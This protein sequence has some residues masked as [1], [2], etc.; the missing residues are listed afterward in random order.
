MKKILCFIAF[1]IFT[2]SMALGLSSCKIGPGKTPEKGNEPEEEKEN[3]IFN[4]TSELYIIMG[5]NA[6]SELAFRLQNAVDSA[7]VCKEASKFGNSS[8][9]QQKHE[10]V[11]GNTDRPISSVAK[12]HLGRI[13]KLTDNEVSFLIYSD[14][15]SVA[16]VFDE[17]DKDVTETMAIEYFIEHYTNAKEM[18]AAKGDLHKDSFDLIEDYYRVLDNEYRNEQWEAL[19]EAL[20]EGYADEFVTAMQQLYSLYSPD[21]VTWYANL[22]E[23]NICI[24]YGLYGEDRCD[25][26]GSPYCGTAGIYYS[27][28]G[29]DTIGYLPD[30]E[31]TSQAI[32]FMESSGMSYMYDNKPKNWLPEEMKMKMG[33]YA[34]AMQDEDGFFYHPQWGRDFIINNQKDSRRARDLGHATNLLGIAALKPFYTTPTGVQGSTDLEV[35]GKLTAPFGGSTVSAVS[36]VV[37]TAGNYAEHLENEKTFREYLESYDIRHNSYSV[38]NRIGSQMSQIQA[39]DKAIGT[40]SDPTPLMDELMD[41]LIKNQNPETGCWNW[42]YKESGAPHTGSE[43][44]ESVNGLLK[45]VNDFT[46]AGVKMPYAREAAV[47]AMAAITDPKPIDA[48]TSL[49]NTWYAF[50]WIIENLRTCGGADGNREADELVAL[51]RESAVEGIRVSREKISVFMNDDGSFS[52]GINN[53]VPVSAQTSQGC[54]V[55]LPNSEEGDV[56]AT[57]IAINGIKNHIFECLEISHLRPILFGEAERRIYLDIIENASSVRKNEVELTGEPITFDDEDTG[58]PSEELVLELGAGSANVVEDPRGEGNV[59]KIISHSGSGDYITVPNQSNSAL[60]M[61]YVFE[62]EFM[63]ESSSLQGD[64]YFAQFYMGQKNYTCYFFTLTLKDGKVIAKEHSSSSWATA[65]EETL[66]EVGTLGEWFK[67]KVEYYYSESMDDVRIKFWYD[68]N[69]EDGEDMKLLAVTDNFYDATGNKYL[70]GQATPCKYFNYTRFYMMSGTEAVLYMDNCMT[71]KTQNA[72][73]PMTDINNQPPINID[74]P[75]SPE[76]IYDFEDGN[77][78]ADFTLTGSGASVKNNSLS[79]TSSATLNIPVNIR[80]MGARCVSTSFLITPTAANNGSTVMR[81][82]GLD[83][84]TAMFGINVA[85]REDGDGKYLTLVEYDSK[86]TGNELTNVRIPFGKSTNVRLDY[87]HKEDMIIIYVDG[88]F[89]AATNVFYPDGIKGTMDNLNIVSL[90]SS[91]DITLDNIRVEKN[92]DLFLDA[93]APTTP[94]KPYTFDNDEGIDKKGNITVSGGLLAVNSKAGAGS[95]SV[96][97]HERANLQ[98]ILKFSADINIKEAASDGEVTKLLFTDSEGN[99]IFALA[100]VKRGGNIDLCQVSA[101]GTVAEPLYSYAFANS[102]NITLEI[103]QDKKMVHLI[104]G[105]TVKAK[106]SVFYTPENLSLECV[107]ATVASA[108]VKG[109]FTLDNLI[110]ESYYGAYIKT[111]IASKVTPDETLSEGLNF[112]LSNS[113]KLPS[114]NIKV[115]QNSPASAVR[116]E[117][118]V[119]TLMTD[120]NPD[121][122]WSNVFAMDTGAGANDSILIEASEPMAGHSCVSFETDIM[123]STDMQ[124]TIFQI[125]LSD[126]SRNNKIIMIQVS[127]T[128]DNMIQLDE[129]SRNSMQDVIANPL[130]NSVKVGEWFNLRVEFYQGSK[131]TV[132]LKYF[133]NGS[134]VAISNNFYGAHEPG[135][136]PN[137]LFDCVQIMSLSAASG[138]VYLDN[139]SLEASNATCKEPVTVENSPN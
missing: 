109:V 86:A 7:R 69:L 114:D 88:E 71:Y 116:V 93:V 127:V 91:Y 94:S 60:A 134:L 63:L 110:F 117:Q 42:R 81:L 138:T 118:M 66:G 103:Y 84:D 1:L 48:V 51:I 44:Y 62:S 32:G 125:F 106:T 83:G 29:R 4:S 22:Y 65:V 97:V 132:R 56:N 102:F 74:P 92:T 75:D 14:G 26:T 28:S 5:E 111:D 36:M 80:T 24:C 21:V 11:I 53:G 126:K 19:R 133:I 43:L 122:E 40:E 35:S 104:E 9:E 15:S 59:T 123:F 6:S 41:Y 57:V 30:L 96:S 107:K 34:Q 10:I 115:N 67:I 121:G 129:Q 45:I 85:V 54:Q 20:G 27:N 23:P 105:G 139:V 33:L 49:Y 31:S 112:E 99:I 3:L 135:S 13:D 39:R 95:V 108:G 58:V 89:V 120:K 77:M 68:D 18:V 119:N 78:P 55:A 87:F 17:D 100:L 52:Y 61:T 70:I 2:L 25:G 50:G 79:L 46:I 130:D 124:G 76:K 64:S 12:A 98:N 8:T 113:G 90:A 47:T 38:G 136:S 37:L 137:S 73:V 101:G 16:I 128:E 131:S 82:V 72:Y